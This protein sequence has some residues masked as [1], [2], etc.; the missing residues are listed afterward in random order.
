MNSGSGQ[1]GRGR[2]Q[3][4]LK[5]LDQSAIDR[6]DHAHHTYVNGVEVERADLHHGDVIAIGVTSLVFLERID[7]AMVVQAINRAEGYRQFQRN[8]QPNML[9]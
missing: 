3:P 5:H 9:N 2:E 7:K 4:S 1:A 8:D 6:R